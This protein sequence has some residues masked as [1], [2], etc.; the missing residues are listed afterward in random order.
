MVLT[1]WDYALLIFIVL[2]WAGLLLVQFLSRRVLVKIW[3]EYVF[4]SDVDESA[5]SNLA[6][7][8]LVNSRLGRNL[9]DADSWTKTKKEC[10][11][12]HSRADT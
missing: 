4:I 3:R 10:T 8:E 7:F 5:D 1:S 12:F 9:L 11:H 2:C 6:R